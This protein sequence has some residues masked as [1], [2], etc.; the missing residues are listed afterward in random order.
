MSYAFRAY[1]QLTASSIR[2]FAGRRLANNNKHASI[3]TARASLVPATPYRY[4]VTT[5]CARRENLSDETA[6]ETNQRDQ[7]VHEKEVQAGL[8]DATKQQIRRPW[9]REGAD[10][11]PVDDERRKMNKA[12]TKGKCNLLKPSSKILG[13]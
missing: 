8:E 1:S 10:R 6:R 13:Y 4:F 11:P 5:P 3:F 2:Q 9:L 7:A 12:M